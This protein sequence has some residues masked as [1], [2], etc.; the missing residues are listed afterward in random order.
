ME[1]LREACKKLCKCGKDDGALSDDSDI[2][3][4]TDTSSE[5]E[6]KEVQGSKAA[7]QA[8][9]CIKPL[10]CMQALASDKA[11]ALIQAGELVDYDADTQIFEEGDPALHVYIIVRGSVSIRVMMPEL[12]N[13]PIPVQSLYDGQVFG[14]AKIAAWKD[15]NAPPPKRKGGARTQEDTC[16]LRIPAP[17]YRHALGL[18][19]KTNGPNQ[20][21]GNTEGNDEEE[22]ALLPEVRRKVQALLKSPLFQGAA[23]STLVLLATNLQEVSLRHDDVF[24]EIDQALQ[25]C[26]LISQGYVRVSVPAVDLEANLGPAYDDASRILGS[27]RLPHHGPALGVTSWKKKKREKKIG[28]DLLSRFNLSKGEVPVFQL[29]M[30]PLLMPTDSVSSSATPRPSRLITRLPGNPRRGSAWHQSLRRTQM[31]PYLGGTPSDIELCFLHAGQA[32]GLQTLLDKQDCSYVSS[33]E[34]RVQSSEAKIL[35]LTPASLLYLNESLAQSLK[36]KVGS[37]DDPVMSPERQEA[38]QMADELIDGSEIIRCGTG[39]AEETPL[40]CVAVCGV[41][42]LE[43]ES[44]GAAVHQEFQVFKGDG[45]EAPVW[46][47]LLGVVQR[48][49]EDL[50]QAMARCRT[51]VVC[52]PLG[53]SDRRKVKAM[54]DGLKILLDSCPS[55]LNRIVIL[56]QI[57]AQ[58]GGGGFNVGS[59]FGVDFKSG[60]YGSLEDEVTVYARKRPPS[61]PLSVLVVR[62]GDQ[63][64]RPGVV[65][66]SLN[67]ESGKTSPETVAAAMFNAVLYGVN[68]NFTVLDR[69]QG[70][71]MAWGEV[72]LPCVGPE[73]WRKEVPDARKAALFVQQWASTFIDG[74]FRFG[75]KTPMEQRPTP[76]GCELRFRPVGTPSAK[77]MEELDEGGLEFLAELAPDGTQRL[78][79]RRVAYSAKAVIKA[80]SERALLQQF[81]RDWAEAMGESTWTIF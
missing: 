35:V 7:Q 60:S 53:L 56:S 69:W 14:D 30:R 29:G 24:M 47:D 13:D 15:A 1:L 72:L 55:A 43:E 73:V 49:W 16:M 20:T 81:Q 52:P 32:F 4:D 6:V 19:T 57:G 67:E 40:P 37:M 17:A 36:D 63:D 48:S 58:A 41:G 77:T 25:A 10:P 38:E 61:Q 66:V 62:A 71:R 33:C 54:R 3:E 11:I 44:V 64:V 75:M 59:F 68:A 65:Q 70:R 5:E 31:V 46:F 18:D 28:S 22:G 9:E 80:N 42:T 26:F 45:P 76:S 27:G 74:S 8:Y 21:G 2:P 39:V 34:V 12:G 78:R 51:M 79:C 23:A 50:D